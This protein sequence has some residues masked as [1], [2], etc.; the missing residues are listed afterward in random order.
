MKLL[1]VIVAVLF[2]SPFLI[3]CG[4]KTKATEVVPEVNVVQAGQK[5]IPIY[6]E[7]V[8]QTY[9]QSDVDIKPR[10]EGWIQSI[11]FKEGGQVQKGQLLYVVQDDELRDRVQSAEAKLSEANILL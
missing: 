7:Y 3:S 11:H 2:F 5:T 1:T 4:E 9:G 8:G 6:A 10:V